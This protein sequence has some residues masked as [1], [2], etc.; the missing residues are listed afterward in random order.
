MGARSAPQ[1]DRQLGRRTQPES[2]PLASDGGS[3][4]F[5]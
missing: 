4:A 1:Y 2:S 3:P 5:E